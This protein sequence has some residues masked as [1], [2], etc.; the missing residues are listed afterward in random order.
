MI[1]L[2]GAFGRRRLAVGRC[3]QTADQQGPLDN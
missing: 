3:L 2:G 1:D